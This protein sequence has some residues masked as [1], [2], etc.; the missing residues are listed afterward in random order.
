MQA[1]M[2]VEHYLRAHILRH[3]HEVERE[4]ERERE[5]ASKLEIARVF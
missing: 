2:A 5:R 1:G 4:R 3:N